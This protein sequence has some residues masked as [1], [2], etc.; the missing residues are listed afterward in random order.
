LV[1]LVPKL[2]IGVCNVAIAATLKY[3]NRQNI[4]LGGGIFTV[5][6]I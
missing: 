5:L 3:N 6:L 4:N 2:K 1:D